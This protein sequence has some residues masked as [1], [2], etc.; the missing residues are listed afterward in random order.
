MTIRV[1]WLPLLLA[2]STGA[3]AQTLSVTLP[4]TGSPEPA[5]DRFGPG[6][7]V[8]AGGQRF[9]FDAG[10]GVA[11]RLWQVDVRP[12][13]LTNVLLT[14]LQSGHVVGLPVVWLTGWQQ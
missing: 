10:R 7:L 13:S 8:E 4:G 3:R 1:P 12:G 5:I 6:T 9:L 14:Y 11:Q 2:L